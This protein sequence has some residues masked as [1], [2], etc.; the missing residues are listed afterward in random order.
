MSSGWPTTSIGPKRKR[1]ALEHLYRAMDFLLGHIE[2]LE[3]ELFFRT[4]DLFNADVD[5]IFW[6]TTTLYCEIDEEDKRVSS[7]RPA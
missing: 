1:L 3:Q 7:G 4:A 2:S 6:D 5:L